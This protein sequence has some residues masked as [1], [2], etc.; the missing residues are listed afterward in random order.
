MYETLYFAALLRLPRSWSRADK[1]SRVEMVV[2]GLGLERC[3]DTII[4]SHMMRGVSGG[5]RK[6]VSIG[7]CDEVKGGVWGGE[8]KPG[9]S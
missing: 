8:S 4:G 6:R 1:L 2:E 9:V 7:A 5:E 3:R